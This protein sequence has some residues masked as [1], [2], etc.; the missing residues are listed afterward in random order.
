M[1]VR[2]QKPPQNT[3]TTSFEKSADPPIFQKSVF[4][5]AIAAFGAR[6]HALGKH[7]Q[8]CAP[9]YR[10]PETAAKRRPTTQKELFQGRSSVCYKHSAL[11]VV[12]P[13]L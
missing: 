13:T 10:G 11:L 7:L 5:R 6:L 12:V 2:A 9:Q 1:S 4:L 8:I 3:G